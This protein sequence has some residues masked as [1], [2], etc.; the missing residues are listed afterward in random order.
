[1]NKTEENKKTRK[2]KSP[3]WFYMI[4][5]LI[6]ILFFVLLEIILRIFNYGRNDDQWIK[7]TETKQMLNPDVAL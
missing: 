7:I 1:M 5:I 4:L 2:T 3:F 6:P